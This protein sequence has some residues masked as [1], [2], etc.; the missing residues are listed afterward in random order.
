MVHQLI[1]FVIDS[2]PFGEE[3][4]DRMYNNLP[5][6]LIRDELSYPT[7]PLTNPNR[8]GVR[9]FRLEFAVFEKIG[10]FW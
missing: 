9:I 7:S 6:L 5:W 10:F 8:P 2:P 4:T 3:E 1:Q